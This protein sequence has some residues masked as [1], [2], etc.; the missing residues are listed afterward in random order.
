MSGEGE[1]IYRAVLT[2]GATAEVEIPAV[3]VMVREP[4]TPTK[5]NRGASTRTPPSGPEPR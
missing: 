1:T 3:T 2:L 4:H 5:T